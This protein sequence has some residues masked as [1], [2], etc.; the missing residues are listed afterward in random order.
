MIE[1]APMSAPRSPTC[2]EFFGL[3]GLTNKENL[4][5]LYRERRN[6]AEI[7]NGDTNAERVAR[8]D[9]QY[10]ECLKQLETK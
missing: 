7:S 5:Q 1:S 9:H 4:D 2:W 3:D 10:Q 8:I 6:N